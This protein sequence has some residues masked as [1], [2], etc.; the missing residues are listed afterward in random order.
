[1]SP[2]G[3]AKIRKTLMTVLAVLSI[4][5]GIS[6]D[7]WYLGMIRQWLIPWSSLSVLSAPHPGAPK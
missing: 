5:L 3:F 4:L 6:M 2:S 7:L 1:M